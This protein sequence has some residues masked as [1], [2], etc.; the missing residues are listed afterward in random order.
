MLLCECPHR[1]H[2][3]PGTGQPTMIRDA[4]HKWLAPI[5]TAV[6][7]EVRCVSVKTGAQVAVCAP[8]ADDL[9]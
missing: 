5:P 1:D 8:C 2:A 6:A 3:D 9:H 7:F 4:A